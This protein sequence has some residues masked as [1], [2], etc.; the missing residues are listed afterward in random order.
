MYT[1]DEL[2]SGSFFVELA[3]FDELLF[4]LDELDAFKVLDVLSEVDELFVSEEAA[5]PDESDVSVECEVSDDTG[6]S[7]SLSEDICESFGTLICSE[8]SVQP[9][10]ADA[11][12]TAAKN[13]ADFLIITVLL[14]IF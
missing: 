11:V 3:V 6:A 5:A 9:V 10:R 7:L 2:F 13:K 8:V 4:T 1:F 14:L 12:M